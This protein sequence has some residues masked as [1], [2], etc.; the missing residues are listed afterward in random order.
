MAEKEPEEKARL[1]G[2]RIGKKHIEPGERTTINLRLARLYTYA[3][4]YM[5][6]HVLR[7]AREPTAAAPTLLICAAVHGDEINGVEIIRRLLALDLLHELR[8]TLIAI[9]V[10]NVHGFINRTRYLPDRRDLNRSFPGSA[11]G[12]QA[13]QLAYMLTKRIFVRCT[14]AIDLHT[15]SNGRTNL[16]QIRGDLD[17]D[18]VAE[19]ATA[20]GAPVVLHAAL[21]DGSM[22]QMAHERGTPMLLYE[23]GEALRFDEL[24]IAVGVR[25]VLNVMAMLDMLPA[26]YLEPAPTPPLITRS[27]KW[28][29]SPKSGM[30]HSAVPIG[31][32]VSEGDALAV[33]SEPSGE[34]AESIRAPV[35]GTV[36]GCVN[37]PL[38]HRGNALFHIAREAD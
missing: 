19:L 38:V 12:S 27:S 24:S 9:P 36:I 4:L 21:R 11:N 30:V 13:S 35:G 22:R 17:S 34:S 25:G 37:L 10:V 20:F 29:R 3:D 8:G 31:A 18:E 15:G 14:H 7:G 33:V 5:P 28:V 32:R 26:S 1:G 2:L 6:V 23:A 16:P